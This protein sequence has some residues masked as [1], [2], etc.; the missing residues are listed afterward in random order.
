MS[1]EDLQVYRHHL[2]LG[3][4]AGDLLPRAD[5]EA[6]HLSRWVRLWASSIWI[7]LHYHHS[8]YAQ[9]E[10]NGWCLCDL[11]QRILGLMVLLHNGKATMRY[12]DYIAHLMILCEQ[13][14][15]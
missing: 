15:C 13:A 11:L 2:T 12:K 3:S 4:L 1:A 10:G 14:C 8:S 6:D 9:R 5:S 7:D